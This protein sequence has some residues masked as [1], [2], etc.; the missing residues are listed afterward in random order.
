MTLKMTKEER[1]KELMGLLFESS[2]YVDG[3]NLKINSMYHYTTPEGLIKILKQKEII[4]WFTKYDCLNDV[5][6][7]TEMISHY[8][9]ACNKLKA[10]NIMDEKAKQFYDYILNIKPSNKQIIHHAVDSKTTAMQWVECDAYLCCFSEEPNSLD[11][12]RYY[13]KNKQYEGYS[14]G[15]KTDMFEEIQKD[16]FYKIKNKKYKIQITRVIY[17]NLKKEDYY[18]K[19]INKCYKL[20]ESGTK[21]ESINFVLGNILSSTQLIFKHECFASEKEIRAILYIPKEQSNYEIQ[22]RTK[23]G[24]IIPYIEEKFD[25]K[26]LSDITIGPLINDEIAKNN[27]EQYLNANGYKNIEVKNSKLP[28]RF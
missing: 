6:E 19:I 3:A 5:S 9:V 21:L 15:F 20:Y 13:S 25:K 1:D 28:I 17:D 7:G 23:N 18:R 2:T 22:Y 27:L 10:E 4:L 14:I 16:V 11:L 12:W 8:K 24:Y 26:H